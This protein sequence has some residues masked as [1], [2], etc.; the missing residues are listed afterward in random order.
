MRQATPR[1]NP[2]VPLYFT[3]AE[4]NTLGFPSLLIS[5]PF[6]YKPSRQRRANQFEREAHGPPE[7]FPNPTP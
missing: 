6:L 2:C 7:P 1:Q 5:A 4:D 3:Q